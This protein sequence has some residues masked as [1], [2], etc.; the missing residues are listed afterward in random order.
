MA[1]AGVPGYEVYEWNAV[2][3]PA[4]TPADV[5]AKSHSALAR[6]LASPDVKERI[7]A[8]GGEGSGLPP[9]ETAKWLQGQVDKW[10]RLVKEAN[11]RLE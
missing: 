1:E 6:A 4:G 8:L 11:I 5:I 10:A 7:A 9:A 2:F 3:A